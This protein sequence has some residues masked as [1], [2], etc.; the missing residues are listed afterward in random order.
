MIYSQRRQIIINELNKTGVINLKEIAKLIEASEITIRRD[1]ERLEKEGVLV[2]VS[3]GAI[4]N[5]QEEISSVELSIQQKK[6]QN[7][8]EK[9]VVADYAATLV[10][11]HECVFIDCGTCMIP[12][13]QSLSQ[14]KI[15]IVTNNLIILPYIKNAL[16]TIYIVGGKYNENFE[17]NTGTLA[18]QYISN[19]HFHHCFLGCGGIDLTTH[20]IYTSSIEGMDI[21]QVAMTQSDSKI[22]LL[23]SSKLKKHSLI[24]FA[25]LLDMDCVI[26]N[27]T[28][29]ALKNLPKHFLFV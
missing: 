29:E 19:Y 7:I 3:G 6:I 1:F 13:V 16:A 12:L 27:K 9:K 2:R 24:S 20:E 26:C 17:M 18:C 14:R 4:L 25:T 22:L 23:D 5:T 10:K 15:T 21:K 11:D 28:H 8:Q